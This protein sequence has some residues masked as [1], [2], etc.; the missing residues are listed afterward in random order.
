M[1][2]YI[3][4]KQDNT[5][6]KI[7]GMEFPSNQITKGKNWKKILAVCTV[8]PL[9]QKKPVKEKGIKIQAPPKRGT[10]VRMEVLLK[11]RRLDRGIELE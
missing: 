10:D 2:P 5:N 8:S 6:Q 4:I 9:K 1:S 3:F 11:K 7:S